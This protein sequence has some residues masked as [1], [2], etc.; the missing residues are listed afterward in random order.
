MKNLKKKISTSSIVGCSM[1]CICN[2]KQR[3][4]F[5]QGRSSVLIDW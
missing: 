3:T 5:L 4:D 1:P 2:C